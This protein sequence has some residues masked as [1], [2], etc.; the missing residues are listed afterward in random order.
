MSNYYNSYY[1]HYHDI[2]IIG[3]I[4]KMLTYLAHANQLPFSI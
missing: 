4:I 3:V 2:S 1:Y